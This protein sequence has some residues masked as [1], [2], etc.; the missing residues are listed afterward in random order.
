MFVQ[1]L[2]HTPP[3]VFVLFFT[4]L[5]LGYEQSNTRSVPKGRLAV[6]PLAMVGL[7]LYGVVSAFG[8]S[9]VGIASWSVA[10]VLAVLWNHVLQQPKGVEYLSGAGRFIVPG[11]WLPLGLMMAIFFTKYAAAVALARI[12]SLRETA[13]FI[14]ITSL[15]YGFLSGI[16]FA[17]TLY[18]WRFARQTT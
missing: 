9:L 13:I 10:L 7:S 12:P 5:Y 11:S 1:I 18:T 6:L 8:A 3:W 16:F 2:K 17:R 4:L 15:A 14:I